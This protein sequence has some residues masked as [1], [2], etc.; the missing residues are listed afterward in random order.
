MS[1][2]AKFG[3]NCQWGLPTKIGGE[4]HA[5]EHTYIYIYGNTLRDQTPRI[6]FAHNGSNDRE[7]AK[8]VPFEG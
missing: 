6:I 3:G 5:H 4:T 2:C 1:C 8:C 7:S